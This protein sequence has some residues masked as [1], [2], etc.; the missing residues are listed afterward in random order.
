[1]APTDFQTPRKPLRTEQQLSPPATMSPPNVPDIVVSP[2]SPV[3]DP[4][5]ADFEEGYIPIALLGDGTYG[6]A[7]SALKKDIADVVISKLLDGEKPDLPHSKV[8][9]VKFA[10][11]DDSGKLGAHLAAEIHI[12]KHVMKNMSHPLLNYLLDA[13]SSGEIQWLVTPLCS[14][15]DLDRFTSAYPDILTSSFV[16][17]VA[18]CLVKS[19]IFFHYGIK[20]FTSYNH[21]VTD[22]WPSLIHNDVALRN[23][24]IKPQKNVNDFPDI[25]L[26]DFGISKH[27]LWTADL[28]SLDKNQLEDYREA[29][30]VINELR[31][32]SKGR[33]IDHDLTTW[34]GR[35]S[36]MKK[37]SEN[38]LP[39]ARKFVEVA[40]MCRD[41]SKLPMHPK[42]VA[43]LKKVDEEGMKKALEAYYE[44]KKAKEAIVKPP[45]V[46]P[47]HL[48]KA[49][50][51]RQSCGAPLFLTSTFVHGFF[52]VTLQ[53]VLY[54][55]MAESD[56]GDFTRTVRGVYMRSIGNIHVGSAPPSTTTP[57]ETG[58]V[59]PVP[60]HP[61]YL[62][63]SR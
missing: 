53:W 33:A 16:W 54:L 39:V 27:V 22:S 4:S 19:L 40:R 17:H 3:I 62:S 5:K 61:F 26:A 55:A 57:D 52:I 45:H 21:A 34:V 28:K 8:V 51:R 36:K 60:A 47:T 24:F 7:F 13:R 43:A 48:D 30:D 41:K 42:V 37:G 31:K 32:R 58:F 29:I 23:L 46:L 25:I 10:K 12:M 50:M 63:K 59:Q 11:P 44:Q 38:I 56:N 49:S 2:A 1:M 35:L 14:G 9:V 15:G 18:F 20:D 6:E